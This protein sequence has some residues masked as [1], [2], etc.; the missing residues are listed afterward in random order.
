MNTLPC[1]LPLTVEPGELPRRR[2]FY[3]LRREV[4]NSPP[5]RAFAIGLAMGIGATFAAAIVLALVL[6]SGGCVWL[7]EARQDRSLPRQVPAAH[8]AE[9]ERV[10]AQMNSATAAI[11][12]Q[13]LPQP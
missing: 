12:F 6:S 4:L 2:R 13:P 8:R 5:L 1:D 7:Q 11:V 3:A 9:I 10:V